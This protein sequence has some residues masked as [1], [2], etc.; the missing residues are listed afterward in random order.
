MTSSTFALDLNRNNL[1]VPA[2]E[3]LPANKILTFIVA[4]C[5]QI[6]AVAPFYLFDIETKAFGSTISHRTGLHYFKKLI[7]TNESGS[8]AI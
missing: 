3:F 1:L 7:P 2:K 4:E 6:H 5:D 8:A